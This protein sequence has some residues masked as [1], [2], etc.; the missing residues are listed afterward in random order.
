MNSNK[1]K[2]PTIFVILGITGDLSQKEIIPALYDLFVADYL[3]D[4]F[5]VVG[6]ARRDLSTR[7]IRGYVDKI[8]RKRPRYTKTKAKKFLRC[9][10]YQ[11]G[12]FNDLEAYEK[13]HKRI[14]KIDHELGQCGNKLFYLSVPPSLYGD[15]FENLHNSGL[16]EL[17]SAR[18]GWARVLVEKPFGRDTKTAIQL[19]RK[20]GK[21]FREEQ[22]FRI[23]HYLAKETVQNILSF[24]FSNLIFEPIWNNKYVD[25]VEI[26]M[27]EDFDIR[28]RGEF[29]DDIGALKDVGQNHI[30]QMLA[31]IAMGNPWEMKAG[32]IR[33]KREEIINSIKPL[34]RKELSGSVIRGQ[35]VGYKKS[36]GVKRGSQTET[37]FKIKAYI[38]HK[39]WRGIPFYLESGKALNETRTEINIYFKRIIPCFC[40]E[41]HRDHKHSNMVSFNI[42]PTE[43][44]DIRFWAKKPGLDTDIEYKDLSFNYKKG[45]IG[46]HDAYKKI[47]LDCMKGDQTLFT[48]TEE[49]KAAWK[50][51]TPI[52]ENW[53]HLKRK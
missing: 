4:K 45:S 11:Q 24:R 7:Y 21:L 18:T 29:Y 30:L 3:P 32:A 9:I 20:L 36:K 48:N 41:P 33:K 22:I 25:R 13:I 43:G 50:F 44:I 38:N 14:N 31:L 37:Y 15:I 51:I 10:S 17:C 40:A 26:K 2:I 5:K 28:D 42:K 52:I 47:L 23:D 1:V 49:V 34:K 19:D 8:I 39:R 53:R 27:L 46:K 6:F 12:F 16:S 35:Y